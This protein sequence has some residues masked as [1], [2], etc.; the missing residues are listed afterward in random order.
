MRYSLSIW[1]LRGVSVTFACRMFSTFSWTV[2]HCSWFVKPPAVGNSRCPAQT[3]RS[4]AAQIELYP[5]LGQ[6]GPLDSL[7]KGSDGR[8]LRKL[9]CRVPGGKPGQCRPGSS[10]RRGRSWTRAGSELG[11][12][13]AHLECW[14]RYGS[15]SVSSR[16]SSPLRSGW[17][18]D[19][20]VG[21]GWHRRGRCYSSRSCYRRSCARAWESIS[22]W[23]SGELH[24]DD[25]AGKNKNDI[26]VRCGPPICSSL[27]RMTPR[28]RTCAS[29]TRV[30][31][32]G[33]SRSQFRFSSCC[34]G[35]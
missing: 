23:E 24:A 16:W 8:R 12:N 13:E 2:Q 34:Q 17:I 3:Q 6:Q 19:G 32:T 21:T 4:Q 31:D 1:I 28:F 29:D 18:G 10:E 35:C 22:A 15:T 33:D 9:R 11:A 20:W 27:S 5:P 14:P 26:A 25:A 7:I 30:G